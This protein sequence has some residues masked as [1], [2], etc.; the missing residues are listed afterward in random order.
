MKVQRGQFNAE[1]A[2]VLAE[3][4]RGNFFASFAQTLASSAL[5]TDVHTFAVSNATGLDL[6]RL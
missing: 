3:L 4:R 2:K 1:V 6:R 5:K